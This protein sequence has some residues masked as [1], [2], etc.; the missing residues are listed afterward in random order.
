MS[1]AVAMV[2]TMLAV[3]GCSTAPTH[4]AVTRLIHV[5][6]AENFWGSI[7]TQLGGQHASVTS[8]IDSPDAD[9]HDYEPRTEDGRA[10]AEADLVLVNGIGY[11]TWASKLA[12]ANATPG[13]KVV[14]VGAVVGVPAGGNP[15]RWYD[16]DDVTAVADAITVALSA[17]DPADKDYFATQRTAFSTTRLAEYHAVVASIRARFS[18]TPVGASESIFALLAP[19]LGLRLVTPPGFLR[20]VSD[21][22]DPT[23]A[24]KSA[25]DRQIA[26]RSIATYVYNAQNATPDVQAQISAARSRGIPVAAITETMVPATSTW[27]DWQTR[28]LVALRDALAKGTGR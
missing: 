9:P 2:T 7:A 26:T 8:I 28:Q 10:V 6:A 5:A 15:H 11:D 22:N 24:D 20:A 25:V 23:T 12:A 16:P 27:E 21:G 19:A 14:T 1:A 18:G 13:Q 17:I 4:G 3:A